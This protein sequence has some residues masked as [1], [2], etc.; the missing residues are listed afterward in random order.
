M[1]LDLAAD[2]LDSPNPTGEPISL[3]EADGCTTWPKWCAPYGVIALANDA[4]AVAIG[5][6]E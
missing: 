4:I 2:E 3:P 6:G 1:T 5:S